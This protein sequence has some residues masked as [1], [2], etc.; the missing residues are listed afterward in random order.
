MQRRSPLSLTWTQFLS[1]LR[2]CSGESVGIRDGNVTEPAAS[3]RNRPSAKGTELCLFAGESALKRVDLI[4]QL[5]AMAKGPRRMASARAMI[6]GS[7]LIVEGLADE[8]IDG[9]QAA[10]VRTRRPA[11]GFNQS[12]QAGA[13]TTLRSKRIKTG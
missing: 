2:A 13:T 7:S 6:G 8:E 1:A 3:L 5:N 4:E 11:L 10:V 9:V 12:Q